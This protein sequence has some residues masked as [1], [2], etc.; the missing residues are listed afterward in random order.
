M[1]NSE[2]RSININVKPFRKNVSW[3][4]YLCFRD[5]CNLI[6][7]LP[8]QIIIRQ[9][10]INIRQYLRSFSFRTQSVSKNLNINSLK[11]LRLRKS[12]LQILFL[13]R[14]LK[15]GNGHLNQNTIYIYTTPHLCS[16]SF[17]TTPAVLILLK[18]TLLKT[19]VSLSCYLMFLF[20]LRCFKYYISFGNRN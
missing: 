18:L 15:F 5:F 12:L 1:L 13:L 10:N 7:F 14:Y 3:E 16:L 19:F 4:P 11:K 6:Y 9:K 8:R 17:K 20:F 2:I